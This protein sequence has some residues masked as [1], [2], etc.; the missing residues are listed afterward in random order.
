MPEKVCK[1]IDELKKKTVERL[2]TEHNNLK[3]F[4]EDCEKYKKAIKRA[5]RFGI[6]EEYK[7]IAFL[8]EEI[9]YYRSLVDKMKNNMAIDKNVSIEHVDELIELCE[10][11]YIPFEVIAKEIKNRLHQEI[12]HLKTMIENE[13]KMRNVSDNE[14][15]NKCNKCFL[16]D[17]PHDMRDRIYSI[18]IDNERNVS[19]YFESY[20]EDEGENE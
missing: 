14:K 20:Y 8:E 17:M 6:H 1:S 10:E 18:E 7:I 15:N 4:R 13:R 2:N 5:A 9:D 11:E 12:N 3:E 16:E 19:I